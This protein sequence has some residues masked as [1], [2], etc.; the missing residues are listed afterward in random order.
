MN[1]LNMLTEMLR[2]SDSALTEPCIDL[3]LRNSSQSR[4][5]VR[6]ISS[7]QQ[8]GICESLLLPVWEQP[9]LTL[10]DDFTIV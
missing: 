10:L 5:I 4:Q 9:T 1:Q 6:S 8:K 3:Q 7:I 2:G